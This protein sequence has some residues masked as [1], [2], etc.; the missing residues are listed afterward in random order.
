[1]RL[2]DR[3]K[4]YFFTEEPEVLTLPDEAELIETRKA[5]RHLFYEWQRQGKLL[6]LYQELL[7]AKEK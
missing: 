7:A 3:I 2:I 4:N 1:M 6:K 5:H